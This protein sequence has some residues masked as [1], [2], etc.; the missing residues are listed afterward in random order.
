MKI[1]IDGTN[2]LNK[3]AELMLHSILEQIEL[4][5][6]QASVLFNSNF[7][8][9][10]KQKFSYNLKIQMRSAKVYGRYPRAI[11]KKLNLPYNI[12]THMYPPKNIDLL[13]DGAGFQFS[14]QWKFSHER[15]DI[16]EKYFWKLKSYG[17][18]IV[19]LPQAFG[20][21]QTEAG[22]R[23]TKILDKYVDIVIARDKI[24]QNYLLS[25]GVTSDK[26]WL[27]P[28]FT[29]LSEGK[30][31]NNFSNNRKSTC[32]IPNVRM[33]TEKEG[34]SSE[35]V[36]FMVNIIELFV[37]NGKTPFLLNHEGQ[38]DLELCFRI[39]R[40]L[41]HDID[42]VTGLNAKEVKGVIGTSDI[43]VSSRFHGV[44]SALSQGIPCLATS[45]NHKYQMLFEDYD[46][47]DNVLSLENNWN[48]EELK[49]LSI[50]ENEDKLKQQ[51][52]VKKQELEQKVTEMWK[53]IWSL[54]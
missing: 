6:P 46:Q 5:H 22:K 12:F 34:K 14:D 8:K 20:P 41:K 48:D 36:D 35:Y 11:L 54:N 49:V 16:L 25:A 10:H 18:K 32:I 13:L 24:S 21:F 26:I 15:L 17:T 28:D 52:I 39:K 44:A 29:L 37:K 4:K 51:L 27:Y 38:D 50:I 19:L 33:I 23:V 40:K 3:G 53:R 47:Y 1:Q 45:W 7:Y 31:P 2:T 30:I 9:E 43:V 42:I